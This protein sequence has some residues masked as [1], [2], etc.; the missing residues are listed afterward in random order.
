MTLLHCRS[1][2]TNHIMKRNNNAH[3][4]HLIVG[5]VPP[6]NHPDRP[7]INVMDHGTDLGIL[8]LTE[9]LG[10]CPSLENRMLNENSN[11]CTALFAFMY[12][13]FNSIL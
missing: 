5:V 7:I 6:F 13:F 9:A 10:I 11:L 1:H 12:Y 3:F 2:K 4:T 8:A